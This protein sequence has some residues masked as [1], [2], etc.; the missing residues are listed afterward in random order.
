MRYTKSHDNILRIQCIKGFRDS[1]LKKIIIIKAQI[2]YPYTES[3]ILGISLAII[4]QY[5]PLL[6]LAP[7]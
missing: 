6:P 4:R 1:H 7:T 5:F 2:Y 3:D